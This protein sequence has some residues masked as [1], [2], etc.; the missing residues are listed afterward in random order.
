MSLRNGQLKKLF[1]FFKYVY[2]PLSCIKIRLGWTVNKQHL[3]DPAVGAILGYAWLPYGNPRSLLIPSSMNIQNISSY[4]SFPYMP[5]RACITTT[6][7]KLS[8]WR[9]T[10]QWPKNKEVTY[11]LAVP[12]LTLLLWSMYFLSFSLENFLEIA[13]STLKTIVSNFLFK[14]K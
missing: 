2:T 14:I 12:F 1:F 9:L 4:Q 10:R 13:G 8:S 6:A 11:E 3:V 7:G 5:K